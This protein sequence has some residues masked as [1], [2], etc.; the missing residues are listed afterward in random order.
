MQGGVMGKGM[1]D[2]GRDGGN[3]LKRSCGKENVG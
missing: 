2:E 1:L 3:R